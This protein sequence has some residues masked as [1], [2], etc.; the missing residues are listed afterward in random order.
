M[1]K[2]VEHLAP[3]LLCDHDSEL[4]KRRSEMRKQTYLRYRRLLVISLGL[5]KVI[6]II[7]V[8]IKTFK[9]L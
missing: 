7:L 3:Q 5:L 9:T 2:A 6:L 4:P 8:I 1:Q